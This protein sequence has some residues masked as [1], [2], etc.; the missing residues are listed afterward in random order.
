MGGQGHHGHREG[1]AAK[2]AYEGVEGGMLGF[3]R[4]PCG[5]VLVD[6]VTGRR[7]AIYLV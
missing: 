2:G 5:S 7:G 1:E 3:W 4:D 6:E